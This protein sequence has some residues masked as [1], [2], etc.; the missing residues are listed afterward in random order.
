MQ[1]HAAVVRAAAAA[2]EYGKARQGLDDLADEL[3]R[4]AS[5]GDVSFSRY[6]AIDAAIAQLAEDLE[7]ERAATTPAPSSPPAAGTVPASPDAGTGADSTPPVPVSVDPA[8]TPPTPA[9]APPAPAPAPQDN[10]SPGSGTTQKTDGNPG[11]GNSNSGPKGNDNKSDN[12]NQGGNGRG[13]GQGKGQE[14]G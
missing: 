8:P 5:E 3:A 2:G 12:G 14:D 7:A 1:E 6:Q 4:A 13:Q 11:K 9:P 10:N